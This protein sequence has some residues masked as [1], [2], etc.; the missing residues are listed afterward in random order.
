MAAP[1][2]TIR[3]F[4]AT[5]LALV[6]LVGILVLIGFPFRPAAAVEAPALVPATA[7]APAPPASTVFY[8]PAPHQVMDLW[9]PDATAFPGPRP[10]V[11]YVHAGGWISGDRRA[12]VPEALFA[13]L[14]RGYAVA[15]VDY[16]LASTDADGTP[17][18]SFPGA[19]WDVKRAVR[20]L[21]A[22]A[23][24]WELDPSRVVVLGQSA[25]GHLAA[26]V[27]ATPGTLEPPEADATARPRR[28]SSVV[29]A[30]DMV[31]PTDLTTFPSTAHDWAAPL[32]AAFL[33]CPAP[34][35]GDPATCATEQLAQAS[36]ATHVD[37][38]DP[39]V[40]LAYGALDELVV[41]ATQGEPLV[42]AW[43]EAHGG[44]PTSAEYLVVDT[45]G[46]NLPYEET[47]GPLTSF[48]DRVTGTTP[49]VGLARD[50]RPVVLYG[51]SLAAESQAHF[52]AALQAA[53]VQEVRTRTFGGT[54]LCDWLDEMRAD[55]AELRPRTVVVEFSGNAFT[56]CMQDVA[57][58]PLQ[59]DAYDARYRRD[60]LEALQTF[61]TTGTR[62]IFVGT[63]VSRR[64]AEQRAPET[65]RLNAL[66]ASVAALGGADYVDAG[67]TVLDHGRWTARLA[68]LVTEPCTGG[69][70]AS[71]TRVN[72]VRAPDGMHFCPSAPDAVDGVTGECPV[73]SSGAFRFGTAMARGVLAVR[74]AH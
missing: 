58:A 27:A 4:A 43:R 45:A 51:D 56:P 11:L 50:E 37:R 31:G 18:P 59:G 23:N 70:D 61:S 41:P 48:L 44:D 10:V 1:V 40:L 36:V 7:P 17:V 54:A 6:A 12:G 74:P 72:E 69:T 42:H 13:Q 53:G 30:V 39:P 62:V 49:T 32:T 26:M 21:K 35:P 29:G 8:G 33:G 38:T 9:T 60:A 22:Q 67:A 16:Q 73:W 55:A 2:T 24:G 20:F 46:H 63:P 68:C 34:T 15:S 71:G 66:Y 57:G 3:R 64:V 14:G 5:T 47:V 28:D 52:T 19:I 25:G 65:G